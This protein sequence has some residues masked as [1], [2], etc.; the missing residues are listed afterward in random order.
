[1]FRRPR[2][3][4]F[5]DYSLFMA[6][7]FSCLVTTSLWIRSYYIPVDENFGPSPEGIDIN[8]SR[9]FLSCEWLNG[10]LITYFSES[11][12]QIQEGWIF[13]F[14]G[15]DHF[16][17]G[18]GL[19]DTGRSIAGFRAFSTE[20]TLSNGIRFIVRAAVIPF[21]TI[22]ASFYAISSF[23]F[24]RIRRIYRRQQRAGL[25]KSCGYDLRATPNRCPEC[26]RSSEDHNRDKI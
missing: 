15:F 11:S 20:W 18:N 14:I 4:S 3:R 13:G 8:F 19:D 10:E 23:Q 6:L 9:G 24:F 7:I 17:S 2:L 26:G 25:C 16:W 12:Q 22:V 5:A 1:M 21:S